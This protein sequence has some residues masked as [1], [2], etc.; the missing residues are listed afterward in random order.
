MLSEFFPRPPL[1]LRAVAR[2]EFDMIAAWSVDRLGRSLQ[3]L[4]A[5]LLELQSKH[6]DLYVHQ[7]ALDTSTSIGKAM[8]QLSYLDWAL[9]ETQRETGSKLAG[10]RAGETPRQR[11]GDGTRVVNGPRR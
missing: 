10:T 2:R 5:F 6:V 11:H 3:D 8:F 1:L 4:L 9:D 7:Q